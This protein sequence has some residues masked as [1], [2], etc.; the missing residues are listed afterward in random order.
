M[1]NS[2]IIRQD[3]KVLWAWETNLLIQAVAKAEAKASQEVDEKVA[4]NSMALEEP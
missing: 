4:A 2:N 3:S 1:T